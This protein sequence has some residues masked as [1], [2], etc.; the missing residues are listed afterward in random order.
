MDVAVKEVT[1]E[2]GLPLA[3]DKKESIVLQERKRRWRRGYGE[4]VKWLGGIFNESLTFKPQWKARVGKARELVGALKG[5]GGL[6]WG[7]SPYS[8]RMAYT[9]MV[10][11]MAS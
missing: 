11:S 8:S 7:I 6:R 10:R 4:K 1:V 2:F 3:A 5:V 9:D